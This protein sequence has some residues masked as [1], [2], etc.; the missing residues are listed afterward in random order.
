MRLDPVDESRSGWAKQRGPG[1]GAKVTVGSD[2]LVTQVL[3]HPGE[4]L[5]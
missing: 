4:G 1:R 5:L 2:R 3:R